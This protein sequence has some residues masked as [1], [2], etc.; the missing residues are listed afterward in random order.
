MREL[1]IEIP[2]FKAVSWNELYEQKHWSHRKKLA[3]EAHELVWAYLPKGCKVFKGR[4]DIKVTAFFKSK[5]RRDSSNICAKLYEDGLKG[6]VIEDD[7]TRFVRKVT[8][9]AIIG[10]DCDRVVIELS[11]IGKVA[12]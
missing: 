2:Q 9:E 7:D 12:S 1:K 10:A 6:R 4:V 5:R 8:T 3:D 11:E